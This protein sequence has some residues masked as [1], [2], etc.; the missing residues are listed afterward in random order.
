MLPTEAA[1]EA[2]SLFQG[3][4]NLALSFAVRFGLYLSLSPLLF[5]LVSISL[6]L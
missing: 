1:V 4:H 6:S 2:I 5:A 3:R